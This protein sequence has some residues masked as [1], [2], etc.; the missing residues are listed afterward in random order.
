LGL[1]A[2]ETGSNG[3]DLGGFPEAFAHCVLIGAAYDLD[4]ALG[5]DDRQ[6]ELESQ[7]E[8]GLHFGLELG[9]AA[10]RYLLS[11]A[12]DALVGE[13]DTAAEHA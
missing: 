8:A 10:S 4:R 2:E 12:N 1:Y 9:L 11:L 3:E 13:C 5:N 6:I 7:S